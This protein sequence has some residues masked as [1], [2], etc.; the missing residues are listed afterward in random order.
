MRAWL[1]EEQRR[2]DGQIAPPPPGSA[3]AASSVGSGGH[4]LVSNADSDLA[5]Q[6]RENFARQTARMREE[7]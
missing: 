7:A 4:V 1:L 6:G 2:R 5:R 3:A